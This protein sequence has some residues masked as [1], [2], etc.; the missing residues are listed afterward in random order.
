MAQP[1]EL[2]S[3]DLEI[4]KLPVQV[5][6]NLFRFF[7]GDDSILS[8]MMGNIAIDLEN[9]NST[10]RFTSSDEASIRN[11]APGLM[12]S[13]VLILID[14]WSTMGKERPRLRHLLALLIKC[15][16]FRA[17]DYLAQLLGQ[18]EPN[19]PVEGPAAFVDIDLPAA[20]ENMVNGIVNPDDVNLDNHVNNRPPNS[21]NINFDPET[22]R[23]NNVTVS[24][25]GPSLPLIG[26]F[27]LIPSRSK[28][29]RAP[30]EAQT[31]QNFLPAL[32]ILQNSDRI[33]VTVNP[34]QSDSLSENLPVISSLMLNGDTHSQTDELPAVLGSFEVR[35]NQNGSYANIPQ[36]SQMLSQDVET[37]QTLSRTR[38]FSTSPSDSDE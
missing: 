16:L 20:A 24:A 18:S 35:T 13:P 11:H 4:R 19:R 22:S 15:Q 8:L 28:P 5:S 29:R 12:K 32:S 10:L 21:P 9:P 34:E 6:Q 2:L 33:P 1:T 36:I 25:I 26:S 23:T 7:E 17:A 30:V 38:S 37:S 31:S 14:E 27:P 3:G